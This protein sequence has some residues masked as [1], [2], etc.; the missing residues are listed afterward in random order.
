MGSSPA[1]QF[2]SQARNTVNRAIE[3]QQQLT[4]DIQRQTG[5]DPYASGG[6][7]GEGAPQTFEEASEE[8]KYITGASP[9]DY[10][11]GT[12]AIY[13]QLQGQTD[14][15]RGALAA[16]EPGIIDSPSTRK[17]TNYLQGIVRDYEKGLTKQSLAG[18]ERLRSL[19]RMAMEAFTESSKNPA[20]ENM[21]NPQAMEMAENPKTVSQT[22]DPRF[23]SGFRKYTTYNV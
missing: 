5:R 15:M 16:F 18:S 22:T 7:I 13:P 23:Q 14:A 12:R 19:P 8:L 6:F 17:T 10:V 21:L 11:A 20:F 1:Q 4:A 9:A 2:Q 3:A